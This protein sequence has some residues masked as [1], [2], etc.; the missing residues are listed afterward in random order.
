MPPPQVTQF[1]IAQTPHLDAFYHRVGFLHAP[2]RGAPRRPSSPGGTPAPPRAGLFTLPEIP[3]D[4]A[5]RVLV[6]GGINPPES[7]R[8]RDTAIP[9]AAS[10]PEPPGLS[11]GGAKGTMLPTTR[12]RK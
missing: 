11:A 10:T 6:D 12:G 8:P 9:G 7:Y 5:A 1:G 4:Y 2:S 3:A